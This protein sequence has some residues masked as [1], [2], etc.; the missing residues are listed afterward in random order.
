MAD[1]EIRIPELSPDRSA[2][3]MDG[4][5]IATLCVLAVDTLV[6]VLLAVFLVTNVQSQRQ[7]NE[8]YQRQ[9]DELLSAIVAG[10]Q[11]AAADR[12]AQLTML[13]TILDPASGPEARRAA[14]EGWRQA[15]DQGD[16]TRS[17]APIPTQ[18]CAR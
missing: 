16:Q 12:T 13:N 14:V 7:V 9:A 10:R 18:R 5:R 8:C 3:A 6:V 4:I 11:A 2:L 17:S 1:D 15:L